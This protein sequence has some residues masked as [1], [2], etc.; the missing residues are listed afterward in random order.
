M[1]GTLFDRIIYIGTGGVLALIS[2]QVLMNAV[3]DPFEARRLDLSERL[4][5]GQARGAV[6]LR[7]HW[8]FAE[9]QMAL[10][11]KDTLWAELVAAPP[12]PPAPPPKAE[13]CPP[14][15]E[16]LKDVSASRHQIGGK[17]KIILPSNPRGQFMEVGEVIFGA[18]LE[19]YDRDFVVF[20]V[21]C[22]SQNKD[23]YCKLPRL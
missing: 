23:L 8:S 9:W 17:V 18:T 22:S 5:Q 21:F 20:R 14:P 16:A 11:G 19:S 10:K 1:N 12:P 15:C 4:R 13:P 2:L 3:S 7:P 6:D